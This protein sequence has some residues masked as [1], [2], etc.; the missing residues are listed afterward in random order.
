MGFAPST[1]Y[2]NLSRPPSRRSVTDAQL[3][4]EI[5][6]IYTENFEVYGAE[7]VWWQIH[8]DG[9]A[10]GRDR[11]ARLMREMGIR[12]AVRSRHKRTTIPAKAPGRPEDLVKRN[13]KVDAPNRLWVNDLT[14]VPITG[15]FAY[16]A[17]VVDAFS[18]RIVGWK[19]SGSLE[20]SIALDA[21]EMAVWT[22][23]SQCLEGLVH[24]SDRGV[25]YLDIRYSTRLA[26]AGITP[27]VGSKG[28][29]LFTTPWR[30]RSTGC[31]RRSSYAG[32]TAGRAWARSSRR[33]L[34]GWRGGT[35]AAFTAPAGG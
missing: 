2:D 21:L 1:Y 29:S 19:V 32:A 9:I 24:H 17:L 13:F 4:V 27:S 20:T 33:Q 6:R 12:G 10:C 22:R 35:T 28:D 5:E 14:Y 25:Q 11:V 15:G 23:R 26:E 7:K 31:T 34:R 3:K 8:R 18:Q 16:T 30:R